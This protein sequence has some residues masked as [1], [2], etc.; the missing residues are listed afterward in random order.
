MQPHIGLKWLKIILTGIQTQIVKSNLFM[1]EKAFG[2][3]LLL[4]EFTVYG[5]SVLLSIH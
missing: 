4:D 1:R 5:H 2:K 3:I